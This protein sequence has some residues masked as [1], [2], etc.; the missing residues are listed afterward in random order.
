MSDKKQSK[1]L[2]LSDFGEGEVAHIKPVYN[3]ADPK[4]SII[5]IMVGFDFVHRPMYRPIMYAMHDGELKVFLGSK[6]IWEL[7]NRMIQSGVNMLDPQNSLTIRIEGSW[8]DGYSNH[9]YT[10]SNEWEPIKDN[11]REKFIDSLKLYSGELEEYAEEE[12]N[13][14]KD[15][16]IEVPHYTKVETTRVI[17]VSDYL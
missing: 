6:K 9:T 1:L 7:I 10:I 14:Y 2:K 12:Q 13:K 15:V 3:I 16:S 8:K 5:G 4:R 11:A 17:K